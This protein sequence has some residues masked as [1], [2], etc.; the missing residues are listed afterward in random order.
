MTLYKYE[1]ILTMQMHFKDMRVSLNPKWTIS[2]WLGSGC[3]KLFMFG[4]N[5][6]TELLQ[7]HFPLYILRNVNERPMVRHEA[8]EALDSIAGK[9]TTYS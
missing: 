1:L 5:Y 7:L 3:Y 2:A 9:A 8:A 6:K 4:A